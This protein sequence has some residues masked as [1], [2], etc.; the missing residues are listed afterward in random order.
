MD[1]EKSSM[2]PTMAAG[3]PGQGQGRWVL[4]LGKQRRLLGSEF[5][6][7]RDATIFPVPHRLNESL[8]TVFP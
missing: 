6:A 1:E 5:I 7:L 8:V 3:K 2:L 4:E